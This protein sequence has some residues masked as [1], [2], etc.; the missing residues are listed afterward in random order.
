MLGI[1][2][3]ML[4]IDLFI[5]NLPLF[6]FAVFMWA[7]PLGIDSFLIRLAVGISLMIVLYFKSYL[8]LC[9]SLSGF[10]NLKID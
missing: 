8:I 2:F 5:S 10:Y 9:G 7:S 1:G 6:F 4:I 3:A